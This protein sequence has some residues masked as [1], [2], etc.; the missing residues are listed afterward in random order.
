[1]PLANRQGVAFVIVRGASVQT[2]TFLGGQR[3]MMPEAQGR[4]G[5]SGVLAMRRD[6]TGVDELVDV[7][8]DLGRRCGETVVR[9]DG[10]HG[11]EIQKRRRPR[12]AGGA[13]HPRASTG[14]IV[15]D[16][17]REGKRVLPSG[18]AR[19]QAHVGQNARIAPGERGD[20]VQHGGCRPRADG[21]AGQ[22][23]GFVEREAFDARVRH[24]G[25]VVPPLHRAHRRDDTHARAPKPTED[26]GQHRQTRAVHLVQIVDHQDPRFVGDE[27]QCPAQFLGEHVLGPITPAREHAVQRGTATA[28]ERRRDGGQARQRPHAFARTDGEDGRVVL[29]GDLARERGLPDPRF[30][31][32]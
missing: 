23:H 3:G 5:H 14:G 6:D 22:F 13:G 32:Q 9:V 2:S 21:G 31:R 16:A 7:E 28:A 15:H 17:Q 20:D 10:S 4:V 26:E 1:M 30:A 11:Q 29:P 19:C 25:E 24:P 8:A 18:L 12:I 27:M